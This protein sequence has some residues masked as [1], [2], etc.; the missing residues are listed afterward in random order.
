MREG[1]RDN[2]KKI[3]TK[4][5][6]LLFKEGKGQKFLT[7]SHPALKDAPRIRGCQIY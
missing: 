6:N 1:D 3:Q 4:D 2:R 7:I 5:F